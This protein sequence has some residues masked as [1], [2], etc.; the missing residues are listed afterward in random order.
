MKSDSYLTALCEALEPRL[1]LSGSPWLNYLASGQPLALAPLNPATVA[2]TVAQAGQTQVYRFSAPATGR[3]TVQ[4]ASNG[5]GL[6]PFLQIYTLAGTRLAQNDNARPGTLDSAASIWIGSGQGCYVRITGVRGST[7]TY[8][9][10]VT[11]TPRDDCGNTPATA[12][13]LYVRPWTGAG[14]AAGAVNYAGDVDVRAFVAPKTGI[15]RVDMYRMFPGQGLACDL[16]VC[17]AQ[18]NLLARDANPGDAKA[19]VIVPVVEGRTYYVKAAA[20]GGTTGTYLVKTVLIRA[21]AP[22]KRAPAARGDAFGLDEDGCL[23]VPAP[24]L[25]AND[26]DPDGDS[27][28]ALLVD[29]VSH[30]TLTLNADGS[31]TYTPAPGFSGTDAF[32]YKASD[33]LAES[34]A[35]TVAVTVNTVDPSRKYTP[36]SIVTAQA[37]AAA[38][39]TEFVV[40]GTGG[41]DAIT[42]AQAGDDLFLTTAMGTDTY[43]GPF[44][45]MVICGFAG[46]DTIRIAHSVSVPVTVYAGDGDDTV[47]DAGTA[48]DVIHGGAGDDLLVSVGGGADT[49]CGEDGLDSLWGDSADAMADASPEETDAG[50]VHAI[51]AFYQPS[52]DPAACVWLEI[53]GQDIVDPAAGY[54]YADFSSRPLFV[55]GPQY[56]DIRQGS[57]G[58][59]Y[60][61]AAL[62]SLADAD[63][64]MIRQ[65]IAPMGDGTYAVRFYSGTQAVYV[66]VDAWL[67]ASGDSP[68]YARLT[69][70]DELW[71]ALAEKAYAQFRNGT[72]DYSALSGGWMGDVYQAVTGT[73]ANYIYMSDTGFAATLS[74]QLA[75]GHAMSTMTWWNVTGPLYANHAYMV[76]DVTAESGTTFVTVYN[77]YGCNGRPWDGNPDDGLLKITLAQFMGDFQMVVVSLA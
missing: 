12:R 73:G 63:P 47:Y 67:P 54:A 13:R 5:S 76:K 42:L 2:G 45:S 68:A 30:G 29:G 36:G 15:M 6:D 27:L 40:I 62:A 61:L 22:V 44:A 14:A 75:A 52:P 34:G 39:R 74:E 48:S 28:T 35:V 72:N 60:F 46:D 32:T 70:A 9:L 55:D 51:A 4:V 18:E 37:V 57:V 38:G 7:G 17:D 23:A 11:S 3:V 41:P 59:C 21:P 24:G 25:L 20:L 1:C 69:P 50:A 58:D 19:T 65:M 66:R 49:L 16:A 53:A 8:S 33:G 64:S 77:T 31:F 56:N 10:T 43:A 71:V 26:A